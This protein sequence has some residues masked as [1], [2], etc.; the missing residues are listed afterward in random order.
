MF[1]DRITSLIQSYKTVLIFRMPLTQ[2]AAICK[3]IDC[4][5]AIQSQSIAQNK[6]FSGTL[7]FI[8]SFDFCSESIIV[9]KQKK[10]RKVEKNVR[11]ERMKK[12]TALI[13]Q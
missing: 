7:S 9:L 13:V 10:E 12:S 5:I 3:F 4:G 6:C 8:L 11:R 1:D 2:V